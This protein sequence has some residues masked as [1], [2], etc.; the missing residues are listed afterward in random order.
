M[1]AAILLNPLKIDLGIVT[2]V[3]NDR[4]LSRLQQAQ[5]L[6]EA[7]GATL[8]DTEDDRNLVVMYAGW[9]WRSRNT[10]EGM[11]RMVRYALNNRVL[12]EKAKSLPQPSYSAYADL[13]EF[14]DFDFED[15]LT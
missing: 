15:D 5:S 14:D 10:G 11:P 13:Y 12:G 3:Y 4:L 9:L 6:I 2:D 8:A 7:E 1:D